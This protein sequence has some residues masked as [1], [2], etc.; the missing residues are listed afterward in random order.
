MVTVIA[1]VNF[2]P[3]LRPGEVGEIDDSLA[4]TAVRNG[5]AELVGSVENFDD[6]M[7]HGAELVVSQKGHKP[8]AKAKA[9][10]KRAPAKRGARKGPDE[11]SPAT[12]GVASTVSLA[13]EATA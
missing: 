1:K 8:D 13:D 7:Y 5:Y 9:P 12:K 3:N 2:A 4:R 6:W 10:A 11:G